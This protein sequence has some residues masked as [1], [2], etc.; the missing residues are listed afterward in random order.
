MQLIEAAADRTLTNDKNRPRITHGYAYNHEHQQT[1][2]QIPKKDIHQ[3]I[4]DATKAGTLIQL[5]KGDYVY[6]FTRYP[7]LKALLTVLYQ[8]EKE[9]GVEKRYVIVSN[10]H[11]LDKKVELNGSQEFW[12]SVPTL[13]P[14]RD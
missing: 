11:N 6:N 3:A 1:A 13:S 8:S 5:D 7:T 9:S 2:P 12:D 10:N 4:A 14:H